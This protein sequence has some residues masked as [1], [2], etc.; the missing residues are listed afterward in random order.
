[1]KRSR[2]LLGVPCAPKLALE[3]GALHR[4]LDAA[5]GRLWMAFQPVVSLAAQRTVAFEALVRSDD[6]ELS[7][8]ALLFAVA[9]RTE[10]IHELGTRI[11]S[12]V[13]ERLAEVSGD[14][15]VLVNVHPC[16]LDDP[17]L[18]APSA[19]LSRHAHRVI[20]ELT[21]RSSLD[22]VA[23]LHDRIT[24][25]RS[26][27]YRLAIDD[28]GA[29]YASLSSIAIIKPDIVKLDM[30]LVRGIETDHVRQAIVR[31]VGL[32]C[33]QLGVRWICEGVET[34]RELR[35]LVDCGADLAQGYLV[36]RPATA[37]RE[38]PPEWFSAS[39]QRART[40]A[41]SDA[42]FPRRA[43]GPLLA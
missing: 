43:E 41:I 21:E 37:I 39:P 10:R 20:L 7:N 13:A 27:G 31:S 26:L 14:V 6:P 12:A 36:G 29:G 19:P 38:V 42:W 22:A 23:K 8:P 3:V 30:S 33:E 16:D 25:L 32:M 9:E 17:N 2:T 35:A 1:M 24:A 5:L 28:L 34:A 18:F 4:Q 11:R 40:T 15:D